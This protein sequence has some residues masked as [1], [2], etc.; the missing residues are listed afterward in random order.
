MK[1]F[2][3]IGHPIAHS[4]SPFLFKAAY[5]GKHPYDLIEGDD[6]EKSYEIFLKEYDAINVTAPFKEKACAKAD[7]RSQECEATGAANIL[8]KRKDGQIEAANSDI[9]GVLGSI[10]SGIST[11]GMST[12]AL[13]VGCGGAAMAAA[14][15]T[16][17]LGYETVI[18][19]RNIGK[20]QEFAK[21]LSQVP[22]FK[23]SAGGLDSFRGEFRKA[24][25]IIYTLPLAICQ[26]DSLTGRDI[27]GGLFRKERKVILEANYRDPA[28]TQ[29]IR[30]EWLKTNPELTFISGK[31]WLLNQAVGAYRI[32]TGED[33]DI[34]AMKMTVTGG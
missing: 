26:L 11:Q 15:A 6:F 22:G 20:A 23:V 10:T 2:G 29:G 13:I 8:I 28:L 14:Y 30:Q 25:V 32:F 16:C 5:G 4:L 27:R 31:E 33:P 21:K 17:M 24:G 7:I 18:L 34:E 3:L 12:K 1:K 19:N 9:T